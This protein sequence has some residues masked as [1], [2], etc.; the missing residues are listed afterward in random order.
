MNSPRIGCISLC[1]Q[2]RMGEPWVAQYGVCCILP[3]FAYYFS[4]E[5]KIG[6][7]RSPWLTEGIQ[8]DLSP[9]YPQQPSL[10]YC[11]P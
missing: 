10:D 6:Y 8:L 7:R 9:M 2:L 1:P 4:A 5:G 3:F 11:S